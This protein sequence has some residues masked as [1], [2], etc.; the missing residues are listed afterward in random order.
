MT[1]R[2]AHLRARAFQQQNGRCCYCDYPMWIDN[3][4]SHAQRHGITVRQAKQLQC[5]AEHLVAR[6][7]GGRSN[8]ANVA[9]ACLM[10]NT[11]RHARARPRCADQHRARVRRRISKGKW[12]NFRT[13]EWTD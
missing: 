5:T 1:N 8:S 9:A 4:S 7:D 11:S 12:H 3:Y 13:S 6:K 2:D 10:C